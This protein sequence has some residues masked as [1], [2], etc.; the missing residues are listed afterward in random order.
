MAGACLRQAADGDKS[1]CQ[2]SYMIPQRRVPGA[3]LLYV[4]EH[5]SA[6]KELERGRLLFYV[7][8]HGG[9]GYLDPA[10][11]SQEIISDA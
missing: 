4:P 11:F 2:V 1:G 3:R 8:F 9:R 5:R 6:Q 7:T 10:V